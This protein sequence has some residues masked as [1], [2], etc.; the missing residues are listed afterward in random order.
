MYN[1]F[2]W[3]RK[4]GRF[5][6]CLCSGGTNYVGCTSNLESRLKKHS[7]GQVISTKNRLPVEI[8]T[9]IV[10]NDKYKAYNFEKYLKSG[11]G[12]A[13]LKKRFI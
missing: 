2:L 6:L 3:K 11:S 12:R 1:C 4:L 7:S 10:F 13:F 5:T 8:I 9:Y